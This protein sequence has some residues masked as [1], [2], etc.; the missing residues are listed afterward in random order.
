[1]N[2]TRPWQLQRSPS[3]RRVLRINPIAARFS[4]PQPPPTHT[5]TPFAHIH[6]SCTDHNG[7]RLL[8]S[9]ISSRLESGALTS[10][11]RAQWRWTETPGRTR[12]ERRMRQDVK[13][14][15]KF[16]TVSLF[17]IKLLKFFVYGVSDGCIQT[18]ITGAFAGS[19]FS[20]DAWIPTN[21]LYFK[22]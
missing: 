5:H 10:L 9:L 22:L 20:V 17:F 12:K 19:L 15:G 8:C 6:K 14:I 4:W 13:R 3:H 16:K 1:M 18:C 11:L 7:T 21:W 2:S